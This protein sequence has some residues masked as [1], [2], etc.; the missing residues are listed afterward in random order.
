MLVSQR[1]GLGTGILVGIALVRGIRFYRWH[2]A[3]L[4]NFELQSQQL[5]QRRKRPLTATERQT[6]INEFP[7]T[8]DQLRTREQ[9]EAVEAFIDLMTWVIE[10]NILPRRL[11]SMNTVNLFSTIG[12]DAMFVFLNGVKEHGRQHGYTAQYARD[13]NTN[14]IYLHFSYN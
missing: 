2:V 8:M 13:P 1:T 9:R 12:W 10:D 14:E 3:Y 6:R 11:Q 4:R 5:R 7:Q